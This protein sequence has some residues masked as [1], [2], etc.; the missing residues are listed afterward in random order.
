VEVEFTS[1]PPVSTPSEVAVV[2]GSAAGAAGSP[3]EARLEKRLGGHAEF[4]RFSTH[5]LDLDDAAMK[6]VYALHN[7]AQ[8]F[9]PEA[10]AS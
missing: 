10:E 7:L 2:N 1:L 5:L 6:R 8:K 9:S 3:M 4:D